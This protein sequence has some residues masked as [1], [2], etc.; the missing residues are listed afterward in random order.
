MLSF[1]TASFIFTAVVGVSEVAMF[2]LS[3]LASLNHHQSSSK[4][5]K[6]W[7]EVFMDY[8]VVLMLMVSVLAGTVLLSRDRVVCLPLDP[9]ITTNTSDRISSTGSH[10]ALDPSSKPSIHIPHDIR[11]PNPSPTPRGRRTNLAYQQYV[12]I[13]QVADWVFL[14][15]NDASV[16]F[17]SSGLCSVCIVVV[18]VSDVSLGLYRCATM[19]PS[20]GSP[21]SS[22]TSPCCSLLCC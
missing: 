20:L 21:A 7:W 11:T 9:V 4:L 13:S 10:V 6:P 15:P 22:P 19:R 3:E 8:L 1:I 12:Y 16:Q 17:Y 2:T 18:I 14:S 5:L